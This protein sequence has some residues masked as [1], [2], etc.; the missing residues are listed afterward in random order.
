MTETYEQLRDSATGE[1]GDAWRR[2]DREEANL[3][4]LYRTLRED[5]RYTQEHK[6]EQAWERYEA[7]KE[8]IEADTALGT[9]Q[10]AIR[11]GGGAA[12]HRA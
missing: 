3:R 5:P 2:K 7:A 10:E 9:P 6:A 4:T 1:A 8:K 11:T 12:L